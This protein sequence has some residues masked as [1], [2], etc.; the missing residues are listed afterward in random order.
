MKLLVMVMVGCLSLFVAFLI[1][2]NV[3]IPPVLGA[4]EVG[5]YVNSFD[6]FQERVNG[7]DY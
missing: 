7:M 4:V 6:S 2:H 1:H 3:T 5:D